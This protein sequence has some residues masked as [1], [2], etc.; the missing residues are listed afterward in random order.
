MQ[1]RDRWR[2][3]GWERWQAKKKALT[4]LQISALYRTLSSMTMS[5]E[6]KP[7]ARMAMPIISPSHGIVMLAGFARCMSTVWHISEPRGSLVMYWQTWRRGRGDDVHVL[8]VC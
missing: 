5:L 3:G 8:E 7:L 4:L 6:V 1:A 2:G